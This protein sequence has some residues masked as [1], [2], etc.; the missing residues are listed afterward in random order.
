MGHAA[1]RA[2]ESILEECVNYPLE[3]KF[4]VLAIAQQLSVRDSRGVVVSYIK[5]KA[6]K[7]KESVTVFADEKQTQ[8][9]Y[10]INADRVIDFNAKYYFTDLNGTPIGSVRRQ[11]MKSM[12]KTTMEV[13][14]QDSVVMTITEI[15][16]WAKVLDALLTEIPVVGILSGYLFHPKYLLTRV[17]GSPVLQLTKEPAFFESKFKLQQMGH[18]EPQEETLGLLAFFMTVLL[19]RSRG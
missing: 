13:M 19:N 12:W 3:L 14:Y 17:D 5:Q 2:A 15:N 9:L 7:W 18:M 8:P 4:K 16:P 10:H 1:R 11:G 6:F